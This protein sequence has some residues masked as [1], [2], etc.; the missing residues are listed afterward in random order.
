MKKLP[1]GIQSFEEVQTQDYLYVD[2]TGFIQK[3]VETGKVYFLSRPRRFGKSLL[4]STMEAYFEGRSALFH[5]LAIENYENAK[6]ENQRW[7][8]FPILRFSLSGGAYQ[9]ETGLENTLHFTLNTFEKKYEIMHDSTLDLPDQFRWDLHE[10]YRITGLRTVVLVDEYD[11]PLLEN[12]ALNPEQEERNRITL[13]SFFSILKDEESYL[14]FVFMTGVT[15]FSKVSIFSNLNQLED[16]TMAQEYAGI[17]GITETELE[18]HCADYISALAEENNQ[19]VDECRQQLRTMY[20]GYHFSYN[21][22]GVYNPFSLFNALKQKEFDSYW[23]EAGTPVFL[24]RTLQNSS[25]SISDLSEGVQATRQQLSEYRAD[26]PDP[27]P[28]FYQTGYLTIIGWDAQFR[29]YTLGFPNQEVRNGF[30][31]LFPS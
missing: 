2:K 9:T 12:M 23:F 5:G 29:T 18:M 16:I 14:K 24:I 30:M 8:S 28:L 6:S 7:V 17:C 11:K 26:D 13:K 15:K 10:A 3:L 31:N 27:V 4:V 25:Y 1:I 21:A 19:T 20:D 22:E